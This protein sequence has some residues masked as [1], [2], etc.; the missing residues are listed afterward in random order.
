MI[1]N[2]TIIDVSEY[3]HLKSVE[4]SVKAG[5]VFTEVFKNNDLSFSRYYTHNEIIK[6]LKCQIDDKQKSI[7]DY[8]LKFIEYSDNFELLIKS[9]KK[10]NSKNRY[11]FSQIISLIKRYYWIKNLD[12][13]KITFE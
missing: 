3:E 4:K 1:E 7:E 8:K 13:N 11:L 5:K 10:M 12:I 2:F 9:L 6:D